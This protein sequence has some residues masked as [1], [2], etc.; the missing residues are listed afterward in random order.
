MTEFLL[1]N[2]ILMFAAI[3]LFAYIDAEHLLDKDY[4]EDHKSRAVL[5]FL[6][7]LGFALE[8]NQSIS[9]NIANF[10]LFASYWAAMFDIN[11]NNLLNKPTFF[12]GST[13]KWDIFWKE[14]P[15]IFKIFK[16]SIIP[17]GMFIY[18]LIT[19]KI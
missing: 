2:S 9:E 11:L 13:A 5:R 17:L 14:K 16:I 1:F 10:I 18:Y 15:L 19:T 12:L 6:I 4:I 3:Y 7:T 8:Y